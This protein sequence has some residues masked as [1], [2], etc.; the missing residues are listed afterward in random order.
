MPAW[1]HLIRFVAAEDGQVHL[2]Q[3]VDISRDVG[4]ESRDKREIKA[5][6]INGDIFTGELTESVLTVDHV[7]LCTSFV[8][9]VRNPVLTLLQQL[10][11]PITREQCSYIRCL[12]LNY[13]DHAEVSDGFS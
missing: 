3:L 10:L 6:A 8:I 1:T 2:G 4:I 13:S 5:F 9:H 12:G 7:S 11:C